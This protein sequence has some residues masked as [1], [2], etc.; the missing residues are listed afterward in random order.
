MAF[1][2]PATSSD[3]RSVRLAAVD[4]RLGLIS[5]MADCLRDRFRLAKISMERKQ[6]EWVRRK[7]LM[8]GAG[9]V[10]FVRRTVIR[11]A[12]DHLGHDEWLVAA[13]A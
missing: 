12:N 11:T 6:V 9:V 1:D 5:A 4:R 13:R 2:D 10:S 3:G 7:L 8:I